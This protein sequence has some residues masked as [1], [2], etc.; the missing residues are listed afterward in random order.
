MTE[1]VWRFRMN[2]S[3]WFWNTL[4]WLALPVLATLA[5]IFVWRRLQ[6]TF[7]FFFWFIV[8]TE[9]VGLLRFATA[10]L[11]T[12]KSYFYVYWITDLA[13]MILNFLAVYELFVMRLFPRFYKLAI[14]RVLFGLAASII[15]LGGWLTALEAPNKAAAFAIED[16][17]LDFVLV[18]MLTFFVSL[19][20]LM[21]RQW[22]KY[23][24]GI[25]FGFAINAAAFLVTSA[26][27]VRTRYQPTSVEQ[28]PLIAF[29]ISCLIW[30]IT[31]WK[32]EKRTQLLP[33][34]QLD[35][36][37][38]HQARSWETQLKGWLTP[39]KNKR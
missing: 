22:S 8:A 10:Q 36:E 26:A 13:L 39:G 24:F 25:A 12:S 33:A 18:A 21:G 19:M 4:N 17:V 14:Y 3:H 38:L 28:L 9:I 31:F 34:E 27:W 20:L 11:G 29:D 30:L 1:L 6:R 5:G 23:D 37:M 2:M 16:R 32:P 15:I 7:P 35:P